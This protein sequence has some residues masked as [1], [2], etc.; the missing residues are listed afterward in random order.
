MI[1]MVLRCKVCKQ[2]VKRGFRVNLEIIR[3]V[4]NGDKTLSPPAVNI[5]SEVCSQDCLIKDLRKRAK[6]I[7][8]TPEIPRRKEISNG[9]AALNQS[10]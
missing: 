9:A 1:E 7:F 2:Y 3:L 5:I 10:P 4:V 6:Q 8:E